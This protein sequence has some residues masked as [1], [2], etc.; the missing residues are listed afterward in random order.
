MD[1]A[2]TSPIKYR[3]W[4]RSLLKHRK[5]LDRIVISQSTRIDN[6]ISNIHFSAPCKNKSPNDKV[7]L[8]ANRHRLNE[9]LKLACKLVDIQIGEV[10]PTLSPDKKV[11]PS[12]LDNFD[13]PHRHKEKRKVKQE[14]LRLAKRL[15]NIRSSFSL[16]K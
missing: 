3:N 4:E 6:K 12:F 9:N 8:F 5:Q 11:Q 13:N 7:K 2:D 1:Y 16:E 10:H 15:V 14:N